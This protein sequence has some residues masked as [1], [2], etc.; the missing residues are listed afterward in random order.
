M[1]R[2]RE[3]T[4]MRA[5]CGPTSAAEAEVDPPLLSLGLT[6]WHT[7]V[8]WSPLHPAKTDFKA[9]SAHLGALRH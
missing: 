2:V 1:T 4:A 3:N 5:S 8:L 7:S 6:R 9:A